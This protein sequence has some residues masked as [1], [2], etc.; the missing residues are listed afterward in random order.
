MKVTVDKI[1]PRR[2]DDSPAMGV[3]VHFHL[4]ADAMSDNVQRWNN[5]D[6]N[7]FIDKS[8][9]DLDVIHDQAVDAAYEVL[10]KIIDRR[11]NRSGG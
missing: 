9:K 5:V 6:V 10:K 4:D 11:P 8:I 3:S 7:V 1:L 2:D